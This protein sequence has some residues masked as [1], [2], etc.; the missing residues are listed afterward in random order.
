MYGR[1]AECRVVCG[2]FDGMKLCVPPEHRWYIWL[3]I[4]TS[5]R[6]CGHG[7][8]HLSSIRCRAFLD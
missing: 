1:L 4:G 8:E 7:S 3:E 2:N 5:G 6:N